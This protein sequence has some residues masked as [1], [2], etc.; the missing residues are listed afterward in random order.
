MSDTYCNEPWRTV[1]YDEQGRLGPCCTFRGERSP[2]VNVASYWSGTWLRDFRIS[3]LNGEKPKG[4]RNCW[5][6]ESRG[7]TSQRLEKNARH[8]YVS[9]TKINELFLSFGNICNKTCNICRPQR[10]SLIA[11]EYRQIPENNEWLQEKIRRQPKVMGSVVKDFSGRYLDKISDYYTALESADTIHLDGGEPFIVSQCDKILDYMIDKG[12]T[13]KHIKA[14]T[15]G[16]VTRSQLDKLAQFDKVSFHLSIDGVDDLYELVRPPHTWDWW[17]KQHNQIR[18]YDFNIT[19]ACVAH[20]F[21]VHQLAEILEYM[22]ANSRT[23]G[24]TDSY[25][26]QLNNQEYLGCDVVPQSVVYKTVWK[27]ERMD[28]PSHM[29]NNVQNMIDHL[30]R[31]A[32]TTNESN[33]KYFKLYMDTFAPIKQIKYSNYIPW[34][35]NEQM[36]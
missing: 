28:I 25:L 27:L 12:M 19:Y 21:N 32:S 1:H 17:C 8:G 7:E 31:A 35:K 18:E 3:L 24:N 11:K 13:N 9:E 5:I 15:N 23:Y 20:A 16:S 10:S 26:S 34:I 30:N 36:Q 29:Q 2:D 4:C 33:Q 22:I 14:T 6:K